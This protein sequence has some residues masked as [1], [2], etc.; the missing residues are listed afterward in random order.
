MLD[1][2][3]PEFVSCY[4]GGDEVS[5][6]IDGLA[7]E[8]LLFEQAIAPSAWTFPIMSSV[9]SGMLPTKHGAHDEHR[10]YDAP[11][12]TLAEVLSRAGYDTA[13]F[14]DVPYVGPTTRLDRGFRTLSNQRVGQVS[15]WH[16]ALKAAGRVQ[17][18]LT[19]RYSKL[20]ESR[21][22]FGEALRWLETRRDPERPF[23]LYVHSD[24]TH[25]PLLPPARYRRRLAGLS[26][27]RMWEINQDKQL[28][29]SGQVE[30]TERDFD[31]LR[32]LARAELAF[33]DAWLGTL[34]E[35]FKRRG[36]YDNTL[37]IVAADHGDNFGEHGLLRHGLCLYD[38]LLRVPL[39]IRAPGA[40]LKGRIAPLTRLIDLFPTILRITGVEDE[41][42]G[43]FQGQDLVAAIERDEF[44]GY[45]VAELYRPLQ[46]IWQ[47]RAPRFMD[48]FRRRYDR[49]LRSYRTA[50][51][52]LIWSS[53]GD[54]ELFD[55]EADSGE[56]RNLY[57]QQPELAADLMS[58]LERWL[59]SF[60]HAD[61]SEPFQEDE[62]AM[63]GSLVERL[64]DLGYV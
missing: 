28:F 36:L 8:G 38:T 45:A 23:F 21:V 50:T 34:L 26:A 19:G 44:A 15:L 7:R 17:R 27:R 54:H 24:E 52:K 40:A 30:M 35:H 5:P 11:Y 47:S 57:A 60:E 1:S 14:S 49:V 37:I 43:E 29:V 16:K 62:S 2:L 13:A 46:G 3:R 48:E 55:L 61:G 51:H 18:N 39:V 4:A 41:A 42:A 20:N 6:T 64:R 12:P 32:K 10:V 53:K 58:R 31:D 25:M 56:R 9:F 33:V 59:G 22:L 63:D